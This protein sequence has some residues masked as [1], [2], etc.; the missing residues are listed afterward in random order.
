AS[1]LATALVAALSIPDMPGRSTL[2]TESAYAD[3]ATP[4]PNGISIQ[5]LAGGLATRLGQGKMT[6]GFGRMTLATG[7]AILAL[8]APGPFLLSVGTGDVE[9]SVTNGSAWI[10]DGVSGT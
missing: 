4:W 3:P 2:P 1:V 6:A 7:S 9:I 8:T 10:R 5:P